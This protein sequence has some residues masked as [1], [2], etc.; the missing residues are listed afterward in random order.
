MGEKRGKMKERFTGTTH[1]A[2]S[3]LGYILAFV[4][5]KDLEFFHPER[6]FQE[7]SHFLCD[8]SIC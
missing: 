3:F 6:F 5:S 4:F 1:T 2:E 7:T 8:L